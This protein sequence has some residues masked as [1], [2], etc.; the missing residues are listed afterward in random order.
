MWE[1]LIEII[2]A[3]TKKMYH[4]LKR[5][6]G[7]HI[8]QPPDRCF[9]SRFANTE[10]DL[11]TVL[12]LR[13]AFF[14]RHVIVPDTTYRA[15]WGRNPDAMKLVY[16]FSGKPVGYW[17]VIPVASNSYENFVKGESSHNEMMCAKCLPWSSVAADEVY[18]YVVGAVVPVPSGRSERGLLQELIRGHVLLDLY[19]FGLD[20]MSRLKV[21]GICG[22]PSKTA[23]LTIFQKAG[24][25][26]TE[27]FIDKD[28]N[29]PV[30]VLSGD[31]MTEFRQQVKS[32]KKRHTVPVWDA[33]DRRRFLRMIMKESKKN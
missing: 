24:F 15:C 30:Y 7:R 29:Q 11:A 8:D 27:V 4:F 23:G 18:L 12:Q 16:D 31:G 17:S 21:K 25:V 28:E 32:L 10:D 2:I 1:T 26:R 33:H 13:H 3:L 20:V 19:S 9:T 6:A 14:G 5:P 22:Y